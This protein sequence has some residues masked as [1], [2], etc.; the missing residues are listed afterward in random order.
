MNI[1]ALKVTSHVGRDLLQSAAL[2]RHEHSVVWEYVANGLQ[3][4]DTA[5]KPI[6]VVEVDPKSKKIEIRDNGRGMSITDMSQYFKMHGEN[7]DRKQGKPGRGYFG[8][9]KSAAFG[10]ANVLRI[11]TVRNNKN[12]K[13][14][15][16]VAGIPACHNGRYGFLGMLLTFAGWPVGQAELRLCLRPS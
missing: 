4:K 9:G 8:T 10:I 7:I 12:S 16:T 5:T 11:T 13:V 1:A 3:Y 2:F 15:L 6:V 14:Q